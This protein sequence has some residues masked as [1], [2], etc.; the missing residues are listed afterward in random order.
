MM[1][2]KDKESVRERK[3]LLHQ[4]HVVMNV[5]G[6]RGERFPHKLSATGRE[7]NCLDDDGTDENI[8]GEVT[9]GLREAIPMVLEAGKA[10]ERGDTAA[11]IKYQEALRVYPDIEDWYGA[12]MR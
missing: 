1:V 7:V 4:N 11:A 2:V 10:E 8:S 9:D 12:L 6:I 3:K 5:L